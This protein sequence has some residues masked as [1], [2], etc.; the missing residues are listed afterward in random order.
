MSEQRITPEDVLACWPVHYLEY[1]TDI[2]NGTYTVEDA[3]S[4]LLGLVGSH[5]DSRTTEDTKA[6]SE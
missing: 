6:T 5:W 1:L 2:L 4:D 3:R